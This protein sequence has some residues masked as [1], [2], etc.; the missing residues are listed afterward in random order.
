MQGRTR[1]GL[2][3]SSPPFPRRIWTAATVFLARCV[4]KPS[5]LFPPHL[6]VCMSERERERERER[7]TAAT[8]ILASAQ[9]LLESLASAP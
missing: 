4:T 1:T 2:S 7:E 6:Y 3:F 8:V 5:P 9:V